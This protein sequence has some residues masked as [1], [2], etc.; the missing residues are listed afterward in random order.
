[1]SFKPP[2]ISKLKGPGVHVTPSS[3][4]TP[5][6]FKDPAGPS[7][8]PLEGPIDD[9]EN[10]FSPEYQNPTKEERIAATKGK[11]KEDPEEKE[12]IPEEPEEDRT[13]IE[14]LQDALTG[15]EPP[16][17]PKVPVPEPFSGDR[18]DWIPFVIRAT[19]YF[20]EYKEYYQT[21]IRQQNIQF[22]QWFGGEAPRAWA[23]GL[24]STLGT[25]EEDPILSDFGKLLELATTLWG[26]FNSKQDAQKKLRGLRQER[27]V[28]E[29][30]ATFTRWA[31][32]TGYNEDALVADFYQGLKSSI[33]DLMI[34][35]DRPDTIAGMLKMALLYE[36]RIL[37]RN[38]ERYS[39]QGPRRSNQRTN[40]RATKLSTEERSN[41]LK[42]GLCFICAKKGHR[43]KDCPDRDTAKAKRATT[44]EE[45]VPVGER[46]EDHEGQDF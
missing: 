20:E 37:A 39:E 13:I 24:L 1:M 3:P 21:R 6:V 43:A 28:A 42:K 25:R 31:T 29:Y 16:R 34:N 10:I 11:R 17:R 44:D 45:D 9:P 33:K 40:I 15:K 36:S 8:G 26:P 12:P 5:E 4:V 30:H 14:R 46:E 32:Y 35:I 22:L 2:F 19:L 18:E 41:R 23:Y 7:R 27:T 38:K